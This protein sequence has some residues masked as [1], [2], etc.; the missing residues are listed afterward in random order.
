MDL[1][2]LIF[3][4]G[5]IIIVRL[6]IAIREMFWESPNQNCECKMCFIKD[7]DIKQVLIFMTAPSTAFDVKALFLFPTY[8]YE[9]NYWL[10][11]M[12]IMF[13]I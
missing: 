3:D 9:N 8:H 4:T 10:W 5:G 13:N 7:D 12:K 11:L 2:A 1:L 6:W